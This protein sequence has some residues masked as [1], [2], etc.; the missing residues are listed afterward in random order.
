MKYI[1]F[2]SYE[3]SLMIR[4]S[5]RNLI[6]FFNFRSSR[7]KSDCIVVWCF[8]TW[9]ADITFILNYTV[10][11]RFRITSQENFVTPVEITGS[12][13]KIS[14]IRRSWV[15]G[16]NVY[17]LYTTKFVSRYSTKRRCSIEQTC[18]R[19]ARTWSL[20]FKKG[21]SVKNKTYNTM[22]SF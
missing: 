15:L 19:F 8:L 13:F 3:M 20:I 4:L 11:F 6:F 7:N 18:S 17:S 5:W 22:V 9:N 16:S 14:L 10:L 12:F 1:L 21:S 2:L